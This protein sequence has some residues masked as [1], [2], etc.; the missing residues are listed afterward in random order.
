MRDELLDY[1]ERE[2]IYLRRMGSEFA[3]AYP[4]VAGRLE[5]DANECGDP[6]VERL[7]EGFALLAARIHLRLDDDLPEVSDALLSAVHPQYV[8]PLPSFSIAQF[9]LDPAQSQLSEGFQIP[10][11]STLRSKPVGGEACR[12]QSCYDTTLWPLR[13]RA[14]EWRAGGG[15]GTSRAREAVGSIRLTL[16]CFPGG[17]LE[18]LSLRSL[19]FHLGGEGGLAPALYELLLNHCLEI[20]VRDPT[21]ASRVE[22]L[23][24]PPSAIQPVGFS[25]DQTLLGKPGRA[26]HAYALLQEYFAFPEKFYFVDVEGLGGLGARGFTQQLE[27]TFHLS[28]FERR[29][30]RGRLEDGLSAEAFRLGCTPVVNLFP[31]T[32]EPMVLS[33]RRT[34]YPVVPDIRRRDSVFAY[35]VDEVRLVSPDLPAPIEVE[36]FYSPFRTPGGAPI[37]WR[38]RRQPQA[39]KGGAGDRI[40]LAFVDASD[41]VMHPEQD[42]AT[43]RLTCHNGDLPARLPFGVGGED[44]RLEAGG[45]IERIEA[46]VKPTPLV[47]PS[48]GKSRLWRLISQLSLNYT[49]LVEGGATSLKQLLQLQNLGNS[50]SGDRQIHGIRSVESEPVHARVRTEHGIS[51]ARGHRIDVLFDEEEF[52]GGSLYLM[53]SVLERFFG[54]YTSMNSFTAFRARSLQ[55]RNPMRQ[56]APRAGRKSLV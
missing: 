30:W 31:R 12:F 20:G 9:H 34:E 28:A 14:A 18:D 19:R 35:S 46:L 45:P 26:L 3:R 55:R 27:L 23:F 43:L 47:Q 50:A 44:F 25:P 36:P 5:L 13:V 49:A 39:W 10:R 48:L 38:T 40:D 7:L 6:H 33:Q 32:S 53:A 52:A 22:P 15:G 11:G 42:V 24:L 54:L 29:D 41:R 51:F 21:P 56:W 8:R 37:Y 1:Y 2:L 4:K 16:E 17:S